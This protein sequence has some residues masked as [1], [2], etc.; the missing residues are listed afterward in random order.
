M[1]M[2]CRVNPLN[3]T[4]TKYVDIYM[5]VEFLCFIKDIHC[6][7]MYS[8]VNFLSYIDIQSIDK[9]ALI[10]N[11]VFRRSVVIMLDAPLISYMLIFQS[12]LHYDSVDLQVSRCK[13]QTFLGTDFLTLSRIEWSFSPTKCTFPL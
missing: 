8:F 6:T 10:F 12:S 13:F 2:R 3:F 4:V 9:I 5:Y 7:F 1:V 11:E